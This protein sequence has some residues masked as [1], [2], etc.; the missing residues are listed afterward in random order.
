[1]HGRQIMSA[2]PWG[3]DSRSLDDIL[4]TDFIFTHNEGETKAILEALRE[5][6]VILDM[7]AKPPD[8]VDE[9]CANAAW[10]LLAKWRGEG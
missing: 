7:I 10:N 4:E 6:R 9:N 1:M 2:K 5:A 3:T 8:V